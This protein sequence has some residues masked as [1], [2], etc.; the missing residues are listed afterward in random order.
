MAQKPR[1]VKVAA[2]AY[3][4]TACPNFKVE[5]TKPHKMNAGQ[6]QRHLAAREA[7]HLKKCHPA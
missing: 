7:Q 4:C 6:L 3:A 5:I 2:N 1:L